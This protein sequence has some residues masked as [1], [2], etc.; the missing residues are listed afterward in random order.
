[1][2]VTNLAAEEPKRPQS[3]SEVEKKD[4]DPNLRRP[5]LSA[6][7]VINEKVPQN[8]QQSRGLSSLWSEG[9]DSSPSRV[10]N[11]KSND[12]GDQEEDILEESHEFDDVL[13]HSLQLAN[14]QQTYAF[15]SPAIQRDIACFPASEAT[16]AIT[17]P[18]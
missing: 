14:S 18:R 10:I 2:S 5:S 12:N 3:A 11:D 13:L 9:S 7:F 17:S 8:H 6:N 16:S 1:M 4:P 15:M